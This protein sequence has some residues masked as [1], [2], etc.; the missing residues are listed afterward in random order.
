MSK[1]IQVAVEEVICP[2][3]GKIYLPPCQVRCPL[4]M[5]IQRSHTA[6]S[7]LSVKPD[8]KLL[9]KI[10]KEMFEQNPLFPILCGNVCGL[11]EEECNYKDE[12]GAIRRRK[13][14]WP[15]G[16]VF[17][18][19]L[20]KIPKLPA[21]TKGKVAV[22]G[23]GPGGL[24]CAYELSKKGYAVTI[25]ERNPDL[26]G[27]LRY[28]P[29]YRLPTKTLNS[30]FDNV[31]RIANI[32]VKTGVSI[33]KDGKSLDD[34]KKEGFKAIFMATGTPS[35]RNLPLMQDAP[36]VKEIMQKLRE[37]DDSHGVKFGLNLLYEVDRGDYSINQYKGKKVIVVGGGNVAFDV[38]RTAR[39]L[40]GKVTLMCLECA[41]KTVKDGIPA[42]VEEI[43]GAEEEGI[44]IIYSRGVHSI[45]TKKGNFRRVKTV[46]CKSVFTKDGQFHP[47]F[48]TCKIDY[49]KGDLLLIT[50]GQAPDR[51]I[52]QNE[53]LL[54]EKGRLDVDP[55]TL[56]SNRKKGVFIG[57]DVKQIGFA[58]EAMRDGSAAAESIDRF[59]KGK[60]LKSGREEL[61]YEEAE[62]PFR[63]IYKDQPE[64][65]LKPAKERMNFEPFEKEYD[66]DEVIAEATR[67]LYC[68]PC[69]SC[70]GCVF[71][72]YQEEIPDIC[73][74]EDLCSG[75]AVCVSLCPYDALSLKKV[76]DKSV[77][78]IDK[79]KCKRCGVCVTA[80]PSGA[81]TIADDLN[82]RTLDKHV[83]K[84]PVKAKAIVR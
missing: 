22:V 43:E 6:V 31:I 82:V 3:N 60:D 39:R 45:E 73:V 61:E 24:M 64:I 25:F 70:K 21:P 83:S 68:G 46:L 57:G 14:I 80:C 58:S 26:G 67:C 84:K 19:Y 76:G 30:L 56:M 32:K 53:R 50:I 62:T 72:D 11:C 75:C 16:K 55:I 13:I 71:L 44:K 49:L 51:D 41:D 27:A 20:D 74:D 29:K 9:V 69:K 12:T 8:E 17:L 37:G 42:D 18:K 77:L 63:L 33:G 52:Y 5:N 78:E 66:W 54:N 65:I 34:L 40:G 47:E 2:V 79:L 36:E 1:K 10:G 4:K 59:I 7:Q 48:D 28:I 38:A 81:I 15:V 35:P 23:G